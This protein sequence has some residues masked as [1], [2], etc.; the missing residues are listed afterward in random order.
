[1]RNSDIYKV[2]ERSE[3]TG[4]KFMLKNKENDSLGGMDPNLPKVKSHHVS[5]A[6]ESNKTDKSQMI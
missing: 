6:L 1:M 5:S 3:V 4:G 2:A